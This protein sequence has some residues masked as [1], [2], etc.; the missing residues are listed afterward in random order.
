MNASQTTQDTQT[1]PTEQQRREAVG[2][3]LLSIRESVTKA[4]LENAARKAGI[5]PRT[6]WY[7]YLKG[8]VA[9]LHR[10]EALYNALLKELK[11]KATV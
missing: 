4:A 6:A 9:F 5:T 1:I 3:Q 10:G 11:P 2:Q 8:K 7:E